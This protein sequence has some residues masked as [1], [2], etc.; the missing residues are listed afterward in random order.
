MK[1]FLT[2]VLVFAMMVCAVP[3]V[4]AQE[5]APTVINE[6]VD[7]FEDGSYA[8]TVVTE[9]PAAGLARAGYT[10][11]GSKTYTHYNSDNSVN[12]SFT[13]TGTFV[14]NEGVVSACTTARYSHSIS[15]SSWSVEGANAAKTGNQAIG[16]ATFIKKVLGVTIKTE[17]ITVTV[18]CDKYGVIS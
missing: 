1:R 6:T 5:S 9:E 4:S 7:Y 8:V 17:N 14:V 16:S 2:F 13:V 10:K 18:T 3:A 11:T 12:W 15:N